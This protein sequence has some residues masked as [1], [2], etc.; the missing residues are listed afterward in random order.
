MTVA[1]TRTCKIDG[2]E[3]VILPPEVA[4]GAETDVMITRSGDVLTIHRVGSSIAEMIARLERLPKPP[5]L[6]QRDTDP[7]GP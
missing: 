5:A 2:E 7:A 3:A 4:F 1:R 6:E